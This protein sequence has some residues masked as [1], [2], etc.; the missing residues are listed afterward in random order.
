M[1]YSG[2]HCEIDNGCGEHGTI[3]ADDSCVCESLYSGPRCEVFMCADGQS[4]SGS[5]H[6][7]DPECCDVPGAYVYLYSSLGCLVRMI[8]TSS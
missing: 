4:S 2:Q 1:R 6:A 5:M 7:D 8:D 3:G